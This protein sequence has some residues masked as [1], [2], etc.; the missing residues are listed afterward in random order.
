VAREKIGE[1]PDNPELYGLYEGN[2]NHSI[3]VEPGFENS[4]VDITVESIMP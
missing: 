4:A 2:A 1:A 3:T